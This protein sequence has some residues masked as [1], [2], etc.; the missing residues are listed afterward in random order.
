[1]YIKSI[2]H[3]K[4]QTKEKRIHHGK[5]LESIIKEFQVTNAKYQSSVFLLLQKKYRF[6]F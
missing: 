1:M 2:H 3:S 4:K 5:S 6:L